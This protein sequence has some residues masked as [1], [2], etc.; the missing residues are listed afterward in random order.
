MT[1]QAEKNK[2]LVRRLFEE[3]LNGGRLMVLD[4]LIAPGYVENNPAPGQ[5]AGAA[6][7]KARIQ[8]L[9]SAF[10]DL[11]YV[12]EEVVGE[13]EIVAVRY[14]WGGTHRGAF[15]GI[16]PTGR[17]VSVRGMDFYRFAGGRIV[18]HWDNVDEFGM[19]SQLGDLG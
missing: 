13:G 10:P 18:E 7:V 12:L 8:S 14:H 15:L 3:V 9:R 19:L 1:A 17:K 11:R 6:G 2:G 5:A 4:A 16:A